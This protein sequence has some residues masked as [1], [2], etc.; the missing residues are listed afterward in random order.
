MK[1]LALICMVL[2]LLGISF[3]A[4]CH[5][6][7]PGDINGDCK[8]N[9]ADF[10][11]MAQGW[12]VDCDAT[13]DDPLCTP[14]DL[15]EDGFDAIAD[16]NDNDPTIYPGA[17]EIPNDGIDQD[18]DGSDAT[19]PEEPA[20]M[21]FVS[22][23]DPGVSGHEPFNGEM[24]K[25]ETTNAQYCKFL[26]A[27]LAS[28]DIY[29]DGS[30]VK[31]ADGSNNGTD[32]VGEIYYRLGGSGR[33]YNGATNGGAARIN[34]SGSSFTVDSGF[35]NHPVSYVSWYGSTAF[36]D[37]Y[38]WRLPTEWEWQA[39]ADHFGEFSYGCGPTINNSIANY[40]NSVHPDGTTVVGSFGNYGYQMS[41]MAGNVWEWTSSLA[42][43]DRVVRGG[44]WFDFNYYCTVFDWDFN[45]IPGSTNYSLGFR[46]CR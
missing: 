30:Y 32:F 8:I 38:G 21:V 44:C 3:G 29:L 9:I 24:S 20:G 46:V 22:I 33:T 15:D 40:N 45:M 13:P 18:C 37:Y 1:K 10:V 5:F 31:G 43:G 16:C 2:L 42:S 28:G 4:D 23:N 41:D 17:P 14:L 12:L 36:C 25:Y 11:I 26:N 34:Y 6:E 19:G 7:L 39:V 27:A 35:E